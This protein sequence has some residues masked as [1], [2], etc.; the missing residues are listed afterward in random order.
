MQTL[1]LR[2]PTGIAIFPLI[3][4]HAVRGCSSI[5]IKT[6]YF[7][8]VMY[9]GDATDVRLFRKS[10]IVIVLIR[11]INASKLNWARRLLLMHRQPSI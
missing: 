6:L 5:G 1:M 2:R 11:R 4:Q 10:A 7:Q 9:S 8:S 3:F